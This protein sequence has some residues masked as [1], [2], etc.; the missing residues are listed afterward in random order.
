VRCVPAPL[1]AQEAPHVAMAVLELAGVLEGCH[2]VVLS[3][4][5]DEW[6]G[7]AERS[8]AARDITRHHEASRDSR[9]GTKL[10]P[11]C[12]P[13]HSTRHSWEPII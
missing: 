1:E 8:A 10:A 6:L 7:S 3:F 11:G 13:G 12:A 9:E 2:A 4:A 5:S